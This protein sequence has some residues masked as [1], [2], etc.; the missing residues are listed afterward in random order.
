MN[1]LASLPPATQLQ[2]VR[3]LR[4]T[5]NP[6]HPIKFGA[7][8]TLSIVQQLVRRFEV[9]ERTLWHLAKLTS[10]STRLFT[11]GGV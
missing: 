4:G 1:T 9:S 3:K 8:R 7:F 10:P 6:K 11:T 5:Y 2:L